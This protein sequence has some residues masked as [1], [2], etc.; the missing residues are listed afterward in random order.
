M[1]GIL[2]GE[3]S[4][5]RRREGGRFIRITTHTVS[6]P[7]ITRVV[8][9]GTASRQLAARCNIRA[10]LET[11]FAR[12]AWSVMQAGPGVWPKL[13]YRLN[14]GLRFVRTNVGTRSP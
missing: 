6:I 2:R 3:D 14:F 12:E 13:L 9:K 5:A 4:A 1:R 10:A 7:A 8:M 11:L